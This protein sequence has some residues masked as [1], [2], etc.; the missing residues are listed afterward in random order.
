MARA[1]QHDD[2]I[3]RF[4]VLPVERSVREAQ[5]LEGRAH[6]TVTSSPRHGPDASV[7]VARRLAEIG[8]TVTVHV[9]ARMMRDRAHVDALL[10]EIA[11]AGIDDVFVIGGDAPHAAGPFAAAGDLLP[12]VRHHPR[13]PRTIGIGGYPE[14]HPK[15]DPST[16]MAALVEKSEFAD[17]VTTQLCFDPDA[18]IRWTDHVRR[19]GVTL[20]VLIGTPRGV[21]R[22]R[23][24]KMAVR[25]GI[26]T[27]LSFL[28]KQRGWWH[29]L[30]FPRSASDRV[31]DALE[32]CLDDPRRNLA[33]FHYYTF[34][35]LVDT[36]TW[37]RER[38]GGAPAP[39]GPGVPAREE[40][41]T[42]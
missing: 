29:L 38:H 35:E 18:V 40:Q 7:A 36:W 37:E 32:S 17:Y 14:G 8:H 10:G 13:A 39:P 9:A 12:V 19:C 20:P 26:G 33:G 41:Q 42:R 31:H 34:D 16:L 4:E 3:A 25:L 30:G 23:L 1:D 11:D 15:I 5:A 22:I 24:M 21:D 27:S 6:L 28:R 2:R